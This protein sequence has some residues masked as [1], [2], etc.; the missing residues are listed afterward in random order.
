MTP[1][2][3]HDDQRDAEAPAKT[4]DASKLSFP[5][6]LV[7]LIVSVFIGAVSGG[8]TSDKTRSSEIDG[9]RSD[10]RNILTQM[11]AKK[12]IDTLQQE[13]QNDRSTALRVALEATQ[14]QLALQQLQIQELKEMIIRRR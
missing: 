6:Q 14:K 13:L 12:D 11:Q 2:R 8:Y 5:L 10:V 1:A 9:L 4:L 3:R 7:V